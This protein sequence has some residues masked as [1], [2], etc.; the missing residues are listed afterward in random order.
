MEPS[1]TNLLNTLQTEERNLQR[2]MRRLNILSLKN[3]NIENEKTRIRKRLE[4]I[5]QKKA[6]TSAQS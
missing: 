2:K 3:R 1:P 5:S 6:N 4:E